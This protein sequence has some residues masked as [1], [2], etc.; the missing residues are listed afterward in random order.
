MSHLS[1][2][3]NLK[4]LVV[5]S[6]NEPLFGATLIWK[7]TQTYTTTDENGA[8]II[9]YKKEN[10]N[11]VISFIGYRT[12]TIQVEEPRFIKHMMYESNLLDEVVV[13]S[14]KK[15]LYISHTGI[16][17][18][19][20]LDSGE[21]LKAACCNL[22]E[23][24]ETNPS[25][26]VSFTDAITGTKQIQM[27]G[28]TGPYIQITQENIPAIK[29]ANQA[30]GLS[31]IPGTWIESI[32]I[33][34]GA[35]SIVNGFESITGQINTELKK[36]TNEPELFFNL[37]ASENKRWEINTDMN[38]HLNDN[39]ATGLFIHY[40]QRSHKSDA[41]QDSFI[42]MPIGSQWN[43]MNRWHYSLAEKGLESDLII[44]ILQDKKEGGQIAFDPQVENNS[45]T[46]WGSE[47]STYRHE[48][49]Y[50]FGKVFPHLPYKSFGFQFHGIYHGQ[51]AYYGLL[52]HNVQQKGLYLNGI[53][54]SILSN[55]YHKFKTGI[56]VSLD[57]YNESVMSNN[58]D[59][60]EQSV[61]TFFEY[62]Y[63]PTE[64]FNLNAGIRGDY[65]NII[66]W[67][68]TPRIHIR[69]QPLQ[70]LTLR[71]SAGSGKRMSKVFMENSSIF[72][73]GRTINLQG[74][75]N[76]AYGLKPESAQN[77]GL[78]AL[79]SFKLF[80]Q[81]SQFQIDYYETSF[82]NQAVIDRESPGIVAI[83]NLD[84]KSFA[85]S[86]QASL[87]LT[88]L[89]GLETRWAYKKYKVKTTY[90]DELK[91]KLLVPRDRWFINLAYKTPNAKW[92]FDTT[93]NRVGAQRIPMLYDNSQ[94]LVS[95]YTTKPYWLV[96][97][98]IR[99]EIGKHFE[100]YAGGENLT[101]YIQKNPI[102]GAENPFES[103]FDAG[104]IYAPT[105][106]RNFYMGLR[107]TLPLHKH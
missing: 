90:Q 104:M 26:D 56:S 63:D 4:G 7:N 91:N 25:V 20:N 10:N 98:Q 5:S 48:A 33:T 31:F 54:Q 32:Q 3:E 24:F 92:H 101:D 39:W 35:G 60:K 103:N 14:K 106:G 57:N 68:A 53:Y 73:S 72:A 13:K 99:K 95:S 16:Q 9:P 71:A 6:N 81:S 23:S 62:N 93:L 89:D 80:K 43:L 42:D 37:F 8:F 12:D 36:P 78:N 34:K 46:L 19:E 70:F 40:N 100:I 11:L 76:K 96:Q 58:Y 2:Q 22:S 67:F 18:T 82:D 97:A 1:A 41:N 15:D 30:A 28:L 107:Y 59:H 64:K 94:N 52:T 84:G 45:N 27:L 38:T 75:G 29:G 69:Y 51:E 86:F 55:T 61:G 49:F 17:Q 50:K 85:R 79:L 87:N 83:Y 105:E 47:N 74:N 65:H 44:K 66:G 102:I 21:L 77:W 88:L